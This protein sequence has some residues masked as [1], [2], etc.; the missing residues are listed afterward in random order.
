MGKYTK[1]QKEHIVREFSESLVRQGLS[2]DE[3]IKLIEEFFV[4]LEQ[5]RQAEFNNIVESA[6]RKANSEGNESL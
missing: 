4:L 5:G 1:E 3:G 2:V 6:V